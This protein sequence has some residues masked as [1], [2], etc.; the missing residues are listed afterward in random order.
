MIVSFANKT[1]KVNKIHCVFKTLPLV[2]FSAIIDIA[3]RE[4]GEDAVVIFPLVLGITNTREWIIIKKGEN[5]WHRG[6]M[7]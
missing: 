7:L 6:K 1:S 4:V 3:M 5:L 2:L